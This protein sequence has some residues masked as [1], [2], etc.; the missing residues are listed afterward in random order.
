MEALKTRI[1]TLENR[2]ANKVTA[3]EIAEALKD[4]PDM[5]AFRAFLDKWGK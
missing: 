5:V 1:Q 2:P 3:E 4:H